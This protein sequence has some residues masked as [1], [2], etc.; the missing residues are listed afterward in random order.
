LALLRKDVVF[1]RVRDGVD[2]F[3][4][5]SLFWIQR[6]RGTKASTSNGLVW[7]KTT[8]HSVLEKA[9]M[10]MKGWCKAIVR[11]KKASKRRKKTKDRL[12]QGPGIR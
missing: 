6:A 5:D 9:K 3:H 11:E 4:R 1:G 12:T 7:K 10:A 2:F 8:R